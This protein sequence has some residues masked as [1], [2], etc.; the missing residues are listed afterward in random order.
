MARIRRPVVEW[1]HWF[2]SPSGESEIFEKAEDVPFGWTK[3]RPELYVP[4]DPVAVNVEDTIQQLTDLGIE[5]D[6]RWGAA[7]LKKVLDD[8]SSAR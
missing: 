4:V 1:P 5:I 7:H 8:R 6:P 3:S 2:H